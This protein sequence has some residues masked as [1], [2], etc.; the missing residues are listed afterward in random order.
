MNITIL[1]G[2]SEYN[3]ETNLPGCKND[4][5]IMKSIIEVS[6]KYDELLVIAE[7]TNSDNVKQKMSEFIHELIDYTSAKINRTTYKNTEID[8]M[9]KSL[10]PELTIKIIDAC[11]SGINY[12]K[13]IGSKEIARLLKG[14]TSK[15]ERCYFM[16]SSNF[17]ESSYATEN[18]SLDCQH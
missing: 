1:I 13:D 5:I 8:G 15:F 17:S 9:L 6:N 12:V 10:K 3:N 7:N 11:D 4:V 16:Y 18:I 14:T 2:V